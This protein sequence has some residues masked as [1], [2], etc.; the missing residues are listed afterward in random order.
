MLNVNLSSKQSIRF[1]RHILFFNYQLP[2][3]FIYIKFIS[4]FISK[5]LTSIKS[6]KTIYFT[7]IDIIFRFVNAKLLKRVNASDPLWLSALFSLMPNKNFFAKI[8]KHSF[9]LQFFR[10]FDY[11]LG[12]KNTF[13]K[14]NIK[15]SKGKIWDYV[16]IGK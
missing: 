15:T 16:Y 8:I 2:K 11:K 4:G 6:Q 5:R 3:V 7:Q 10:G 1:L 9:K 13:L 14:N 12:L